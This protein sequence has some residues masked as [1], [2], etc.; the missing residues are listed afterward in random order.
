MKNFKKFIF[1]AIL[2]FSQAI[3]AAEENKSIFTKKIEFNTP[4]I[5]NHIKEVKFDD[6]NKL[7]GFHIYNP[8][9]IESFKD[10]KISK[11]K[12]DL[13][14]ITKGNPE[15]FHKGVVIFNKENCGRKSFYPST[16]N[17]S[18][19]Q[20]IL[21]QVKVI[22]ELPKDSI[23][24]SFK[25]NYI[26]ECALDKINLTA[27]VTKYKQNDKVIV[28]TI[29]PEISSEK[30]SEQD[31][32]E[33]I[34]KQSKDI[35]ETPLNE[36]GIS[37]KNIEIKKSEIENAVER[38]DL[39]KI[40]Y[41]LLN[42]SNA[43][44]FL[45]Q[46]IRYN[47]P[48]IFD[49]ALFKGAKPT[50]EILH[51]VLD[52]PSKPE[53][54]A[55]MVELLLQK[56]INIDDE[57]IKLAK[58]TKSKEILDKFISN[59]FY[60]DELNQ[61]NQ[62][63][64]DAICKPIID[65]YKKE[66]DQLN[67]SGFNSKLCRFINFHNISKANELILN[68]NLDELENAFQMAKNDSQIAKALE[69][70]IK[71]INNKVKKEK[72][73]KK[74]DAFKKFGT[75]LENAITNGKA[76]DEELEIIKPFKNNLLGKNKISVLEG[77]ITKNK[78]ELVEQLVKIG[79]EVNEHMFKLAFD[80]KFIDIV[81]ILHSK[82]KIDAIL[83]NWS[84]EEA[85]AFLKL[86]PQ[87]LFKHLEFR[88]SKK[89]TKDDF[90]K[91]LN[92]F[93]DLAVLKDT[94]NT[95]LLMLAAKENLFE[96][97]KLLIEKGSKDTDINSNKETALDFAPLNTDSYNFLLN[98]QE[99]RK[100]AVEQEKLKKELELQ[101]LQEEKF[102]N[103]K[104]QKCKEMNWNELFW[105][106]N[107]DANAVNKLLDLKVLKEKNIDLCQID[108]TGKDVF[109]YS[110]KLNKVTIE[111]LEQLRIP[112]LIE[113]GKWNQLE[114]AA[115]ENDFQKFSN[116]LSNLKEITIEGISV[117]VINIKEINNNDYANEVIS[118]YMNVLNPENDLDVKFENLIHIL[119]LFPYED[120]YKEIVIK[121]DNH[122]ALDDNN[123]I[124]AQTL[125]ANFTIQNDPIKAQSILN[126]LL[127]EKSSA[128][129]FR[130]LNNLKINLYLNC[131]SQESFPELL[132]LI[133]DLEDEN[134]IP[135]YVRINNLY[136]SAKLCYLS[137][138]YEKALEYFKKYLDH[139]F[140]KNFVNKQIHAVD[141]ISIC[142]CE[143]KNKEIAKE[144]A[145]YLYK[146]INN[147]K[148]N[149][150]NELRSNISFQ[151]IFISDVVLHNF[152]MFKKSLTEYFEFLPQNLIE[153]KI[154]VFSGWINF[155][156]ENKDVKGAVELY[157]KLMSLQKLDNSEK[158]VLEQQ[159][160]KLFNVYINK[161]NI[162]DS[163]RSIYSIDSPLILRQ[164]ATRKTKKFEEVIRIKQE[165][166]N[167]P[168]S[169]IWFIS[170]SLVINND[171]NRAFNLADNIIKLKDNTNYNSFLKRIVSI[172]YKNF[173]DKIIKI[174]E[175][176]LEDKD[177]KYSKELKE[178]ICD[179]MYQYLYSEN[180]KKLMHPMDRIANYLRLHKNYEVLGCVKKFQCLGHAMC[181]DINIEN[182]KPNIFNNTFEEFAKQKFK[183]LCDLFN[184]HIKDDLNYTRAFDFLIC[185]PFYENFENSLFEKTNECLIKFLKSLT[186]FV[187]DQSSIKL[188]KELSENEDMPEFKVNL[189]KECIRDTN[190]FLSNP[191]YIFKII[192]FTYKLI[193]C[194]SKNKINSEINNEINNEINSE[195][196]LLFGYFLKHINCNNELAL[197]LKQ[198][199][200]KQLYSFRNKIQA[201]FAQKISEFIGNKHQKM[202]LNT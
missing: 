87:Y 135:Y 140:S 169:N 171:L 170:F 127:A 33:V 25:E 69:I 95:T 77:C 126:K 143:L 54:R 108:S 189:S 48:I 47:K 19:L 152:E 113:S 10:L 94:D 53:E 197:I 103:A 22:K 104:L 98:L 114:V 6:N 176:I 58:K 117:P 85:I 63:E 136:N 67:D 130:L 179:Q 45:I 141:L 198:T 34:E 157:N 180:T 131:Y 142:V 165:S 202:L 115:Y 100:K 26:L 71:E 86:H 66:I 183:Y 177:N 23:G 105:A 149:I 37:Q 192:D 168:D 59:Y 21:S 24:S 160:I 80:N 199:Y 134:E 7:K 144:M 139:P 72:E 46:A 42:S 60:N 65:K 5:I 166:L 153:D 195:I 90:N 1:S 154:N 158:K 125:L 155:Y 109:Y 31:I 106:I 89:I 129:Q 12:R 4:Q 88:I 118:F 52:R 83:K 181:I 44:E 93:N 16:W 201:V 111:K 151:M 55:Q 81:N 32:K 38:N 99:L 101:L 70:R 146:Y 75:A 164:L 187:S 116:L 122:P 120:K 8:E 68:A 18:K 96:I 29:Y 156:L 82:V 110:K 184:F 188:I 13:W 56:N 28:K 43:D 190:K 62:F 137:R 78:P 49:F 196:M 163:L 20:E 174:S 27:H 178:L 132:R 148:L 167:D 61:L 159:F 133:L 91:F 50:I 39:D 14:V 41:E 191:N 102:K 194:N 119:N 182:Y 36:L 11:I 73:D 76:T 193:L 17:D 35:L 107:H 138:D 121:I 128:L 40:Y 3:F 173:N 200:A 147:K 145:N 74:N 84:Q 185:M 9:K 97:V 186:E 123:K 92:E 124:S 79:C 161:D 172:F 150:N 175:F 57:S 15:D 112:Q 64:N 2:I 51:K 30:I 162:I